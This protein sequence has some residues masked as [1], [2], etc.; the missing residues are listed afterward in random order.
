MCSGGATAVT[1]G[2]SMALYFNPPPLIQRVPAHS[3]IGD[4]PCSRL[5][6]L[7]MLDAA[8][9]F[10]RASSSYFLKRTIPCTRARSGSDS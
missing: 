7:S 4:P 10:F 9:D 1:K 2:F 3:P 5:S 6:S 8:N